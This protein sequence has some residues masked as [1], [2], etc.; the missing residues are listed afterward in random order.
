MSPLHCFKY[1]SL[2]KYAMTFNYIVH[3][4]LLITFHD[5][6]DSEKHIYIHFLTCWLDT[7]PLKEL[8]GIY[9]TGEYTFQWMNSYIR[10]EKLSRNWPLQ[11]TKNLPS[12][13]SKTY[14]A[15]R[16]KATYAALV[17]LFIQTQWIILNCSAEDLPANAKCP[18]G[19]LSFIL[20]Y[21]F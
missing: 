16:H 21:I 12:W 18:T 2:F 13:N 9:R 15:Q 6:F 3:I 8:H 11:Y 20:H 17:F 5:Y 10:A 14:L 7:H 19:H 4:I 1:L